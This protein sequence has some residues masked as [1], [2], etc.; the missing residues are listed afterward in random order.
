MPESARAQAD[1]RDWE[2]G[3]VWSLTL[4]FSA[5]PRLEKDLG[6]ESP[7]TTGSDGRCESARAKVG[8]PARQDRQ[9]GI[10]WG[11]RV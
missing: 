10:T 11:V 7:A 8:S 5:A 1:S 4:L 3:C 6:C 2:Q 9:A